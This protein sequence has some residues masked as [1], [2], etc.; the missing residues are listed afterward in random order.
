MKEIQNNQ[1]VTKEDLKEAVSEVIAVIH[2]LI[3]RFDERFAAIERRLD[4][5]ELRLDAIEHR[6]DSI[7]SKWLDARAKD[8][9]KD[10]WAYRV[11]K[12]V[13]IPYEAI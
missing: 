10:K 12:K 7:E 5:I 2:D 11:G 9:E 3:E 6:L 8:A 1:F 4:A 13:E